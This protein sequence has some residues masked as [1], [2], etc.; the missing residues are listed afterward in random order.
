MPVAISALIWSAF[1]IF[2]IVA[3]SSARVPLV[4]VLGLF[5]IGGLYFFKLWKF[6]REILETEPGDTEMFKH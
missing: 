3:P 1:A 4:I 2:V 6:D 5:F